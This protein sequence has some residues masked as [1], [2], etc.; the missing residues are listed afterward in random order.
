MVGRKLALAA[1][2]NPYSASNENITKH[3][4]REWC[5]LGREQRVDGQCLFCDHSVEAIM[6]FL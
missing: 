2:L 1:S 6:S 3:N 4:F 5:S